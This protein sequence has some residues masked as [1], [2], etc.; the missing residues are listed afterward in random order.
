MPGLPPDP[1][2]VGATAGS[3]HVVVVGAGIAGLSAAWSLMHEHGVGQVSVLEAAPRVGGKLAL[4]E[5]AGLTVDTGAQ[6]IAARRPDGVDLVRAVGLDPE[7]QAPVADAV[8]VLV[9]GRLHPMPA[10][11]V[12][13]VPTDL[14]VLARAQVL[15]PRALARIPW[16]H[17]LPAAQTG[18]DVSVGDYVGHRIGPQPVERLVGPTLAGVYAGD[19]MSLSFRATMPE[20]YA[21]VQGERSLLVAARAVH[22]DDT[23]PKGRP[24]AGGLRS[25]AGGLGRLPSALSATLQARGAV[26]RTGAVV[27]ELQRTGRRWRLLVGS[28]AAPSWLDAD[29]VVLAVPAPAASRL[30]AGRAIG[31]SVDLGEIEYASVATVTLAYRSQD[32]AGPGGTADRFG[33]V[34]GLLVGLTEPR[35]VT[36]ATWLTRRWKWQGQAAAPGGLAVVQACLGRA[37]AVA[38]L[39][40]PDDELVQLC[41]EDLAFALR[42]GR[43]R[44]VDALV[45]RW[46]GAL[47]QYAVGHVDRVES[48]R[49]S[50]AAVPGLAV[51]GAAYDGIGVAACVGSG[52]RAAGE[53]V[54]GL[55]ARRCLGD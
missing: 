46:G 5:V 13:G 12:M 17:V 24:P 50:V 38:L 26:V 42:W 21:R 51:C 8:S 47:P 34:T 1:T 39:Q 27:R 32:L 18:R 23:H 43:A 44:P 33:G 15:D 40:R 45:T 49:E 55:E 35:S 28:A 16:D 4:G 37:G 41:H 54:A 11:T 52:R 20:L 25:L 29:A 9:A 19:V 6:A 53:V 30:L 14:G 48:I 7:L 36:A 10:A 31:A 22:D 3:P 2:P